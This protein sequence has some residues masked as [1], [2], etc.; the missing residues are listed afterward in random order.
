MDYMRDNNVD[1]RMRINE[2]QRGKSILNFRFDTP[3]DEYENQNEME[4]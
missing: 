4:L 2:D 3:W 1:F